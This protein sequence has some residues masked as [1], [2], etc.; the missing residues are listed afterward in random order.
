M[1]Q[2]RTNDAKT[3]HS[4]AQAIADET[5]IGRTFAH[6]MSRLLRPI[7]PVL[8][9]RADAGGVGR[10]PARVHIAGYSAGTLCP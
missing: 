2:R 3:T 9:E 10:V 1:G 8:I 5:S 4:W 7:I 6:R